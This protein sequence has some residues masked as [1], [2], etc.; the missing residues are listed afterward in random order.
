MLTASSY[1]I[2]HLLGILMIFLSLG[3]MLVNSNGENGWRKR[4]SITHGVGLFLA[5]LGA[6]GMIAKLPTV[7]YTDGWV[8]VK[9]LLWFIFGGLPVFIRKNPQLS[10]SIWGLTLLLGVLAALLA[11]TKPF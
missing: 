3:G 2:I 9:V 5:L 6:F 1:K 11:I 7:N 4:L 8:M 10:K